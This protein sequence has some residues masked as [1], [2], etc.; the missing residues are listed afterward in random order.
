M[1]LSNKKIAVISITLIVV[2]CITILFIGSL[3]K[4]TVYSQIEKTIRE[5]EPGLNE[6]LHVHLDK[7]NTLVFFSTL[8]NEI[9]V[10]TL[11]EAYRGFK[12]KG[13]IGKDQVGIENQLAWYGKES[14]SENIHLLYGIVNNPETSHIVL[15][16]EKNKAATI[17][18][19]KSYTMWY[20]LMDEV[21]NSPITIRSFNDE[22]EML[23]EMGDPEFWR[24]Q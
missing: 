19:N 23:Y 20:A 21:L 2:I 16:S 10:V 6:I 9:G 15:L 4:D 8:Q 17:I 18:K 11:K 1:R 14:P 24:R 13:Y 5:L 12:L 3:R 22:G 7:N